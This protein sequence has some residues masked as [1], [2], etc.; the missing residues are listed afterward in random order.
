MPCQ[1]ASGIFFENPSQ[2]LVR[3]EIISGDVRWQ[4][5]QR[6]SVTKTMNRDGW[7]SG[8][9]VSD[10]E[11]KAGRLATRRPSRTFLKKPRVQVASLQN[12]RRQT[13]DCNACES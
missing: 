5:L 13:V 8:A 7:P 4:R 1:H 2:V 12:R 6:T 3:R 10:L 9:K 11:A